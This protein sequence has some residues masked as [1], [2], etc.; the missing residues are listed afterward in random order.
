VPPVVH[1]FLTF[2]SGSAPIALAAVC[3]AGTNEGAPASCRERLF[4][5]D[6]F[7]VAAFVFSTFRRIFRVRESHFFGSQSFGNTKYALCKVVIF[8]HVFVHAPSLQVMMQVPIG[9]SS[10]NSSAI[11]G[12]PMLLLSCPITAVRM[13]S[14]SCLSSILLS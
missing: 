1:C 2:C 10:K 4:Q 14:C 6:Q 13:R 11:V 8:L 5:Q 12:M 7:S 3:Q 9:S